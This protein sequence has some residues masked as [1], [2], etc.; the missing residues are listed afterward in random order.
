MNKHIA[1]L[2]KNNNIPYATKK[3]PKQ[4]TRIFLSIVAITAVY[5]SNLRR[6]HQRG[7]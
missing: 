2:T 4:P 5:E 7:V 6:K 3:N 1:T